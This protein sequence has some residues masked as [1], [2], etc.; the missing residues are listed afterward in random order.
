MIQM[1]SILLSLI[2]M[3]V[4]FYSNIA[5]LII[6]LLPAIYLIVNLWTLSK[7]RGRP[8]PDLSKEAQ[9]LI[10]RFAHW[11]AFP[12]VA[13]DN[14]A[15][16]RCLLLFGIILGVLSYIYWFQWGVIAAVTTIP[17][18]AYVSRKVDPIRYITEE[19]QKKAHEE[20]VAFILTR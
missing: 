8:A 11:Y 20:I 14:G 13:K 6:Y 4:F 19:A 1:I 5:A 3:A 2:A 7:T 18:M 10:M 12:N 9:D 17:V 16:A 15:A